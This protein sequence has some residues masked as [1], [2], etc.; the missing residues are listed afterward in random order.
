MSAAVTAEPSQG[1]TDDCGG[2]PNDCALTADDCGSDAHNRTSE[3]GSLEPA[4]ITFTSRPSR[5]E[6]TVPTRRT[7]LAT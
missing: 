3:A 7:S 2:R 6:R 5:A 1:A 4:R